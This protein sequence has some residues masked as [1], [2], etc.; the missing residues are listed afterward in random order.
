MGLLK[1]LRYLSICD[2]EGKIVKSISGW[3]CKSLRH[4]HW[5]RDISVPDIKVQLY[6]HLK[7]SINHIQH[8][9]FGGKNNQLIDKE[10]VGMLSI[11]FMLRRLGG[12]F[13]TLFTSLRQKARYK[14]T[15]LRKCLN[16][17]NIYLDGFFFTIGYIIYGQKTSY[18]GI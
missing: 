1:N 6:F 13:C 15:C 10:Y 3:T 5:N 18:R 14:V 9:L 11:R 7:I 2:I 8:D 16:K 4:I 12:H 17:D